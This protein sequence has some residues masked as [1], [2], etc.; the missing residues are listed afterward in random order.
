MGKQFELVASLNHDVMTSFWLYNW[1]RTRTP[2]NLNLVLWVKLRLSKLKIATSSFGRKKNFTRQTALFP[3][4][5][6]CKMQKQKNSHGSCME[7]MGAAG[8]GLYHHLWAVRA[9]CS[10]PLLVDYCL[11]LCLPPLLCHSRHQRCH[12]CA[13]KETQWLTQCTS[14]C[15]KRCFSWQ[16]LNTHAQSVTCICSNAKLPDVQMT[17]LYYLVSLFHHHCLHHCWVHHQYR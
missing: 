8:H 7:T 16:Q 6:L 12:H 17:W 10:L 3:S 9:H 4:H 11:R 5:I 2:Q 14:T 1:P 13:V 15:V